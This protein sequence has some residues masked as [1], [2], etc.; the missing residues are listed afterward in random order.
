[1]LPEPLKLKFSPKATVDI[2]SQFSN[3]P[4]IFVAL[5]VLNF[6]MSR[7]VRL[8]QPANM[9]DIL[10]ALPVENLERS[11]LTRLV[12]PSNALFIAVAPPT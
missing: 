1:M 12:H 2:A 7:D 8:V 3:M 4:A 11:K 5:A 10:R 6:E 9:R